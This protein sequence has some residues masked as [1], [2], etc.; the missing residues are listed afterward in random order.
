V[1]TGIDVLDRYVTVPGGILEVVTNFGDE[2][3]KVSC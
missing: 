2:Q 3:F 1:T